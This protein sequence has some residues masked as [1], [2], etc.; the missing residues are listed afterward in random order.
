MKVRSKQLLVYLLEN[1]IDFQDREALAQAKREYRKQYKKNWKTGAKK[2]KDLRPSFTQQEY[3]E[4]CK[5]ASLLG[6]LPTTYVREL[7]ISNQENK[8]LICNKEQ[9]LQVLQYLS[10]AIIAMKKGYISDVEE[11]LDKAE[12][13]LLQ[14]LK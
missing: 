2:N 1:N 12:K 8:E 11:L 14:Y 7:V 4:L 5:R 13:D 3:E 6:L 10:M 9:L